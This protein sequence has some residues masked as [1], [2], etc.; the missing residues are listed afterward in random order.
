[1]SAVDKGGRKK[2]ENIGKKR[3][4]KVGKTRKNIR[5]DSQSQGGCDAKM[6]PSLKYARVAKLPQ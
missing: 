5:T 2:K 1:M 6:R 4:G 3:K